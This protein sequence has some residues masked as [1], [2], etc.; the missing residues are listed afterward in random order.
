MQKTLVYIAL[1]A[2]LAAGV[3]ASDASFQ[4][5]LVPDVALRDETDTITFLSL[6]VWGMNP[7]HAVAIG[8]ANGSYGQSSGL[9]L[10]GI[11]YSENYTG[12][13]LGALNYTSADFFGW[14]AGCV[15]YTADN[16]SG[17]QLGC[18]NYAGRLTGLQL[19]ILNMAP[20]ADHGLQIG[21]IN[22]LPENQHWFTGGIA[23]EIA[24][25]MVFVNWRR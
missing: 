15:N 3:K 21:L 16:F 14:Q 8:L 7:Q 10:G 2:V 4:A 22:L 19:G 20:Q 18:L 5:S 11:N 24:P 12:T 23:N 13:Q 6:N 17:F 1:A 9:S 25:V